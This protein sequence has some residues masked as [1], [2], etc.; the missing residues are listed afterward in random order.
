MCG[1]DRGATRACSNA[2]RRG[3]RGG[4]CSEK[5]VCEGLDCA[6]HLLGSDMGIRAHGREIRMTEI[7]SDQTRI[8]C[9]LPKPGRRCVTQR[10][11]RDMLAQPRWPG[12]TVDQARECCG[13]ELAPLKAA[14]HEV[15][16]LRRAV[17]AS[18]FQFAGKL[19]GYGLAAWLCSLAASHEQ[20]GTFP[21]R[22][23]NLAN[24]QRSALSAEAR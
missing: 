10:M 16:G 4:W 11:R 24:A 18:P 8:A 21:R 22:D 2:K 12:A 14:E 1:A 23:P 17:L 9:S 15:I 20:R 6:M 3:L 13:R 5:G 19:G 7:L